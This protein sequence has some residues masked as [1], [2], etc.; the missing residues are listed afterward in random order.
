MLR[1]T[2]LLGSQAAMNEHSSPRTT[3][4]VTGAWTDSPRWFWC[5]LTLVTMWKVFTAS[6]LGLIFDECYY[7]E[8]SLHPQACYF[9]HPPL[10]AWLIAAGKSLLGHSELAVRAGA[11]AGGMILALAG[12]ELADSLYGQAAGNRAGILLTLAPILA[13][14]SFLMTPD[15][16]L[17]P[18]WACAVLFV[19]KGL[20]SQRPLSLWWLAAGFAAGVGMLSKYTMV[21]FYAGLGVLWIVSPGQ[22][23]R[24]LAG[25][26]LAGTVS[27]VLFLPVLIWNAGHGWVS[28]T[29]QLHHG[30]RNE[31]E[32]LIQLGNLA[33]YAAFLLVLVSPLLGLFC[34]LT[35][36]RRMSAK[37]FCFPGVFYWTVVIFF[38][39]SAAKA[40]IEANWPMT[41]FVTGLVMVAGDWENYSRAWRKAALALLLVADIGGM[42]GLFCMTLPG[43]TSALRALHPEHLI[44]E[45]LPG[46]SP[47]R[48]QAAQGWGD[49]LSRVE[50]FRGPKAVASAIGKDY[51]TS[52]ADFLCVSTYQLAGI[53]SF[54]APELEPLLWLP[55]HGRARFPWI[56][57]RSWQ[58]RTALV[59]E[60]PRRG[61]VYF[62][63]FDRYSVTREVIS[64]LIAQPLVLWTGYGYH[65]DRVQNR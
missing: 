38:G 35:G 60:W 22:R 30:F 26:A 4:P 17:I 39:I 43:D 19:W 11:I 36:I 10:S 34:F 15:A 41:A 65:P 21:L 31:H 12:R 58:G 14:N 47:M 50:E 56:D 42:T 33:D 53:V 20:Q 6:K 3:S 44:P 9:D 25:T 18:A 37:T 32:S 27:L 2:R 49:L 59:A 55:D 52:D 28:F 63:L 5:I 57:D 62:D 23:A 51:R 54:Y 48:R 7:W 13:G 45:G 64:P 16:A 46:G 1:R 24:I 8:W 61:P 29:H 40:H